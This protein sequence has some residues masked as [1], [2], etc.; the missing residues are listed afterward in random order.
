MVSADAI[1]TVVGIL[2]NIIS[3]GL[4]L[5]PVPTFYRIWKKGAVEQFSAAPYLATL[6]NCMMWVVYGLPL[7]H[8]H[9]TLVL[10]INGLGVLI[11]LCYVLLF[12]LFSDGRKRLRVFLILA[13]EVAFVVAVVLL[14]LTL[15]HTHDRRTLV[16][17]I[18]CVFFGTM[19]YA[20]PLTIMKLVIQTKSVEFL[21]LY[22]AVA[23]FLN[24]ACWTTYALIRFDLFITIPNGLGLLFAVAQLVLH[25]VYYKSTK[26]QIEA[27][28]KM[29]DLSLAEVVV[30]EESCRTSTTA[31]TTPKWPPL[32]Q[33]QDTK[34]PDA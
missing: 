7:V 2:G 9:S 4:F 3:L 1:R 32:R 8:P 14:V 12:L 13:A 24:S 16:V 20:A 10:T 19:M 25:C 26:Q 29:T 11:E 28:R 33:P 34:S 5:S 21:P 22:L 23:F 17:G 6:L 31:T 15:A 18:I 30:P 27:R